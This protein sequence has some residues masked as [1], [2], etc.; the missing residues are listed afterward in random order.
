MSQKYIKTALGL[1]PIAAAV[2]LCDFTLR[3]FAAMMFGGMIVWTPY[4]LAWWLSDG[5]EGMSKWP[6]TG[7]PNTTA[8]VNPFTGKSCVVHHQPWGDTYTGG[9]S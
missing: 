5:F 8:G 6:G 9:N 1:A 3:S 4:W 2:L 7:A